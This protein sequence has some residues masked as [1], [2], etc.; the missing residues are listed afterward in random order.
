MELKVT[1]PIVPSFDNEILDKDGIIKYLNY[2]Q[3]NGVKSIMTTMGTSQYNLLTFEEIFS[4][5]MICLNNFEGEVILGL[6][7]MSTYHLKEEIK[8][9][10]FLKR[11]F[12]IMILYP[13]RY[14]NESDIVDFFY[15][16]ADFSEKPIYIHGMFTR[17]GAGGLYDFSHDIINKLSEHPNILG[18]KEETSNMGDSF[19][20]IKNVNPDFDLILAGGSQRRAWFNSSRKSSFLSGVGSV[21]PIVDE[22]F[23][24]YYNKGDMNKCLDIIKEFET[25]LFD[26]YMKV[27]WHE[28]LKHS[29]KSL[30]FIKQNRKPTIELTSKE[31]ESLDQINKLIK[32]KIDKY[33][34]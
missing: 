15:D 1:Y 25:P 2:I 16:I 13:Q 3:E 33:E 30:G 14:Y 29:L 17:K 9:Y 10:N 7:I 20:I 26:V 19:N 4:L 8:K 21:F 5:N 32:S 23:I 22:K 12:K 28:S 34:W 27:G 31:V 18:M 6:P 24:E 11:N